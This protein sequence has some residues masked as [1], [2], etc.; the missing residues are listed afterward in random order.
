MKKMKNLIISALA[1]LALLTGCNNSAV[2]AEGNSVT[3]NE[4]KLSVSFPDGW[5]VFGGD[6]VYAEV[7]K[8]YSDTFT[9]A[10][11]MKTAL[12]ETGLE[13]LVYGS[14]RDLKSLVTISV[15][16]MTV[17]ADESYEL[18]TEEYARSA[19]DNTI[20]SYQASGYKIQDGSFSEKTYGGKSGYLSTMEIISADE[21]QQLV[22][23]MWEFTF[24]N[25]NDVYTVSLCYSDADGKAA[26]VSVLEGMISVS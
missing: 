24:E 22:I 3:I 8:S 1:A 18:T 23:G 16:D 5:E 26:V 10:D 21:A 14:T 12:N 15:Q 11:N 2:T 17:D 7:Y 20:F 13:Y 9:S 25:K 6:E 4:I 19:H